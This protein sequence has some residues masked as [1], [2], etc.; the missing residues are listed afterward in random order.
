MGWTDAGRIAVG[1]LADLVLL[2]LTEPT[3]SPM[4]SPASH[5]VYAANGGCV[6]T[7]ICDG[8]VLMEDGAIEGYAEIRARAIEAARRITGA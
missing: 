7:T 3:L 5:A 1:A 4:H 6:H 2:D 8:R